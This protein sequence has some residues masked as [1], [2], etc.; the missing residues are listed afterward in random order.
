[1]PLWSG[2]G[3]P[4]GPPC[5]MVGVRVSAGPS[6]GLW[7][8]HLQVFFH[9]MVVCVVSQPHEVTDLRT[10]N[11]DTGSLSCGS[12]YLKAQGGRKQV[13]EFDSPGH[14]WN[15][16]SRLGIDQRDYSLYQHEWQMRD[17]YATIL[18]I[19]AL[20]VITNQ[21]RDSSQ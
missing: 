8:G 2:C 1:M 21:L 19:I 12:L 14:S 18:R 3:R 17:K 11:D 7:L 13:G 6:S 16:S 4:L 5:E 9:W 20:E 15:G 10:D